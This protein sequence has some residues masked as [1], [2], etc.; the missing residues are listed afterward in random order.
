MDNFGLWIAD[1]R[2]FCLRRSRFVLFLLCDLRK[3]RNIGPWIAKRSNSLYKHMEGTP[4]CGRFI[5]SACD[6]YWYSVSSNAFILLCLATQIGKRKQNGKSLHLVQYIWLTQFTMCERW[7]QCADYHPWQIFSVHK[8]RRI[9]QN[10]RELEHLC[11][12]LIPHPPGDRSCLR[13]V[14]CS[15]QTWEKTARD[16]RNIYHG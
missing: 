4:G 15:R 9:N 14:F 3:E 16:L 10:I 1:M 12:V 5:S 2:R 6:M 8:L 13:L 11:K 7:Q